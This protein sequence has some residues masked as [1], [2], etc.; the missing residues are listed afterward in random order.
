MKHY[1]LSVIVVYLLASSAFAFDPPSCGDP[2]YHQDDSRPAFMIP[3]K[4]QHYWGSYTLSMVGQKYL[5]KKVGPLTAF[6]LGFLWEV[7]D[8]KTSLGTM[9]GGI[10]GF[11]YKDLIADGIGVL[12][13]LVNQSESVR[14]WLNYSTRDKEIILNMT[15]AI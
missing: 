2:W 4:A 12:S 14:L 3:D 5:G 11:S 13:A 6:A 9:N 8:S 7:K 1:L 10:V 15:I